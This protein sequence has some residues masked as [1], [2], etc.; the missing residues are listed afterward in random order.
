MKVVGCVDYQA[1][2][3]ETLSFRKGDEITV[4]TVNS[5]GVWSGNL[6]GTFGLFHVSLATFADP[7]LFQAR[8][9]EK[10]QPPNVE[11]LWVFEG[12]VVTVYDI[13]DDG[14]SYCSRGF[15]YGYVPTNLLQKI[16]KEPQ[17]KPKV[18]R[19]NMM[20]LAYQQPTILPCRC[21][22][23]YDYIKNSEKEISFLEDDEMICFSGDSKWVYVRHQFNGWGYIPSSYVIFEKYMYDDQVE[24]YGIVLYDYVDDS[25]FHLCAKTGD[26]VYV[27]RVLGSWAICKIEFEKNDYRKF[28]FPF[29]YLTWLN[30]DDFK[31][32]ESTGFIMKDFEPNGNGELSVTNNQ[33]V[34]ILLQREKWS[35]V[36]IIDQKSYKVDE[37]KEETLCER[38]GYVPTKYIS[39]VEDG[40]EIVVI[41]KTQKNTNN[42][43][44]VEHDFWKIAQKQD[45][46]LQLKRGDVIQDAE[47]SFCAINKF[48][49]PKRKDYLEAMERLRTE[50]KTR[51]EN[52]TKKDTE[53]KQLREEKFKEKKKVE[54][55][56]FIRKAFGRKNYQNYKRSSCDDLRSNLEQMKLIGEE[57][58]KS[59]DCLQ[60]TKKETSLS[61]QI[62]D[63][64]KQEFERKSSGET[65]PAV[66]VDFNQTLAEKVE[67]EI[68]IEP[69]QH[70]PTPVMRMSIFDTKKRGTFGKKVTPHVDE[71]MLKALSGAQ[72]I[73]QQDIPVAKPIAKQWKA[74]A[75]STLNEGK[76]KTANTPSPT[77]FTNQLEKVVEVSE[78]VLVSRKVFDDL[79]AQNE[80]LKQRVLDMENSQKSLLQLVDDLKKEVQKMEGS[81]E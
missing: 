28:I 18:T 54:Q 47:L 53:E 33:F 2:Y 48:S 29:S 8:V 26:I 17:K 67:Q 5:D 45:N 78:Q 14:W 1:E 42:Y 43:E 19:A 24:S 20:T 44:F 32:E 7:P 9:I 69:I 10:Y 23:R 4:R 62:Q 46:T 81:K 11:C 27:E 80:E 41:T 22:A 50:T 60:Y 39:E 71:P 61:P 36:K 56:E 72:T 79:I 64:S 49:K 58:Q 31:I 76:E 52:R 3:P 38:V 6:N 55:R 75:P 57:S 65:S 37:N 21:I 34:V 13:T 74:T 30:E 35:L 77:Q 66:T 63:T 73:P 51:E 12:D 70:K 40:E 15:Y 25:R 59:S 16:V 68:L